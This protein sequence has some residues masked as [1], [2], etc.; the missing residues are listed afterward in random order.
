ML[1]VCIDIVIMVF[2]ILGIWIIQYL[3]KLDSERHKK[4]LF[5][6]KEFAVMIDNLPKIEEGKDILSM[7][8]DLWA[9][10]QSVLRDQPMQIEKLKSSEE[11]AIE[12][13]DI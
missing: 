8:A 10:I 3:I 1:A 11:R 13:I 9:H 2:F 7:K 12:I 5:E 6:T 4:L